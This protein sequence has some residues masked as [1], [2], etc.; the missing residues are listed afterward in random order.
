MLSYITESME[1]CINEF[2]RLYNQDCYISKKVYDQFVD[3]YQD[4]FQNFMKYGDNQTE[5]YKKMI[6]LSQNGY[7]MIDLHN[8]KF[9]QRK[10]V[11]HKD[12]FDHMFDS[13]DSDILLDEEQR[14]A[15]L[16]DEDYSLVIAGAGSGKTTTMA[17]KVKYLVEKKNVDP[18]QIILLAFTNKAADEL[19]ERINGDFNLGI[20]VLTFHK[21]GSEFIRKIKKERVSIIAKAGQYQLLASY[22]KDIVFPN[23]QLL[24]S[25]KE[26]F[27]EE[28]YFDDQCFSYQNFEDYWDYYTNLKYEQCKNKLSEEIKK[29]IKNRQ[30]YN[31]TINGEYVESEGAVKIAN[32]LYKNG[33]SYT[34]EQTFLEKI[35]HRRTYQPDFTIYNNEIPIYIEYYGS[36]KL[37]QDHQIRCYDNDYKIEIFKNRAIH[38]QYHTDLIEL[39]GQYEKPTSYLP[40]LSKLL[41][42]RHIEK[43]KRSE[44]DLFYRLMETSEDSLFYNF[45][46]LVMTFISLFKEQNYQKEDLDRMIKETEDGKLKKQLE[47][48]RSFYLQYELDIHKTNRIDFPDMINFAYHNME[49][50]KEHYEELNYQYVMIDEYQDISVQRYNFSKKLS[51]LFDA[52]IVAVGDDWQSIFSFS[53]SDI[54]LFTK[55]YELMGYAEI[56]KI[57]KTYRNSQELIDLAGE[58]VGQNTE[59][60][61][62]SLVSD[63]HMNKPVELI[64]YDEDLENETNNLVEKLQETLLK[65]YSENPN[66]HVLLLGRYK[67]D[68]DRIIDS[69]AFRK[70]S[71]N[72][73]ILKKVPE[74]KIDFLTVHGAKGLGYDQVI[75]LNALDSTYGFPSKIEDHPLMKLLRNAERQNPFEYSEERRLFYVALTRTKNKIYIMCPKQL[76]YQS[77]FIKEIIWHTSVEIQ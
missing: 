32:Y 42:E 30:K 29:R 46:H 38:D 48:I 74:M 68:L 36:A 4:L 63:K 31:K 57:T 21:L 20:S 77:E 27:T 2:Y 72:K 8:K 59:Q 6:Q 35:N 43:Q 24:K 61:Q 33:I 64:E 75:L 62:K 18:K 17:A 3:Q 10:L 26:A 66:D 71:N 41:D 67:R 49:V 13:V 76:Q 11:E 19:E 39:F 7:Q 25:L 47:I 53:G 50:L 1:A 73:I 69:K 9:I 70:G 52:K 15:I 54:E 37:T 5:V 65:I 45:I 14:K 51:D 34:Y 55:F 28:I 44:K 12:Y 23:K 40:E 16:I 60:F 58:F 56:V 22:I